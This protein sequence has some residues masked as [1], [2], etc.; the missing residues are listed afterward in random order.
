M[1]CNALFEHVPIHDRKPL[2]DA[3]WRV[4]K[5]GGMF[6]I[7]ETPDIFFPYDSPNT[8]LWFV[9]WLPLEL[10]RRYVIWRK[11]V[12]VDRDLDTCVGMGM[13]NVS[14]LEL[15]RWFRDKQSVLL[16]EGNE[17]DI[18]HY[19]RRPT[20]RLHILEWKLLKTAYRYLVKPLGSG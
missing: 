5:I 1:C 11:R 2:V 9:N 18:D 10:K 14:P 6:R 16:D 13:V 8:K 20:R 4:L 15:S 17:E 7:N 3:C 12:P 19:F